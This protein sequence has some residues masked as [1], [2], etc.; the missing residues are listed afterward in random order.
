MR[1]LSRLFWFISGYWVVWRN[2]IVA[3]GRL[4]IAGIPLIKNR[5]CIE[6]GNNVSLR[7]NARS[8]SMGVISPV[9]LNTL[10]PDSILTI[11]NDVGISG[12]VICCKLS[13]VIGSR[14]MI[15]SGAVICD[16]DFHSMDFKIRGTSQDLAD[17]ESSPVEIGDDCFIGARAMILKGVMIGDRSIVGAG[18]VVV[19]DVP[20][21][22]VVAGNPAKVIKD[23][24]GGLN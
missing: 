18:A 15:G 7:S 22:V 20:A 16:T 12:A 8:T 3:G 5:G 2:G 9:I 19:K 17:A 24:K 6:L 21:D 10:C 4:R 23:L 11:G 13:V 1:L 14:V